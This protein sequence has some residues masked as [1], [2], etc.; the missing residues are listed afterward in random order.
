MRDDIESLKRD[1]VTLV[2]EVMRLRQTMFAQ[3]QQVAM[4]HERMAQV[5][6]GAWQW[7]GMRYH[8]MGCTTSKNCDGIDGEQ[9]V[10]R[11]LMLSS[12]GLRLTG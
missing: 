2:S 6:M 7:S 8:A 10:I 1:K 5:R 9:M 4:M 11:D 12:P 3:Q